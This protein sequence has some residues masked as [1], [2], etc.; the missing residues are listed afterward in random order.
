[1]PLSF[2]LHF[3]NVSRS[4][5]IQSIDDFVTCAMTI[6]RDEVSDEDLL[7]FNSRSRVC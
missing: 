3:S 1:M 7:K 5:E 6:E 2:P 4:S